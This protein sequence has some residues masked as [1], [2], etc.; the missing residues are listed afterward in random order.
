MK[1]AEIKFYFIGYRLKTDMPI[2]YFS[3]YSHHYS[4]EDMDLWKLCTH[5]KSYSTTVF[6]IISGKAG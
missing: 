2:Y 6:H 5:V 4:V 3:K 1:R